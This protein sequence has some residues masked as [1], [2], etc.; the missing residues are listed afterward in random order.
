M[1]KVT[2]LER[3]RVGSAVEMEAARVLL[4]AI[5]SWEFRWPKA[6]LKGLFPEVVF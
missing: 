3:G 4:G 1:P 2:A 6:G 5:A